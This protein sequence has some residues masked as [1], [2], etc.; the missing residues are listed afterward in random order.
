MKGKYNEDKTLAIDE[1]CK[2]SAMW[3]INYDTFLLR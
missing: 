2:Y 1:V 3:Y